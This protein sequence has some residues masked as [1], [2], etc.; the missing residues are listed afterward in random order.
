MAQP[1]WQSQLRHEACQG[2]RRLAAPGRADD[3]D[4]AARAELVDQLGHED[5]PPEVEL[6][7]LLAEGLQP[8]IGAR[9]RRPSPAEDAVGEHEG[10]ALARVT[11]DG[12]RHAEDAA[13]SAAKT[14]APLKPSSMK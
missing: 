9:E 11:V 13:P 6:G 2:H 3:G 10:E 12:D 14:G 8:A 5:A 7:V 4:E 1:P